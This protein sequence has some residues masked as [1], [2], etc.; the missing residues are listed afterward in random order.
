MAAEESKSIVTERIKE[1]RKRGERTKL[2]GLGR[3]GNGGAD[4]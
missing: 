2:S 1:A 3:F 4:K